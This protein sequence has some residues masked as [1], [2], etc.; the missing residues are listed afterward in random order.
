MVGGGTR[1]ARDLPRRTGRTGSSGSARHL[2]LHGQGGRVAAGEDQPQQVVGEGLGPRDRR[3]PDAALAQVRD[4]GSV[5]PRSSDRAAGGR[6]PCA[7]RRRPASSRLPGI[8]G[9][10]HCL[11]RPPRVPPA[12]CL[13]RGRSRGGAVGSG[14]R[15]RAR[16]PCG[17]A[18]RSMGRR[19]AVNRRAAHGAVY[20]MGGVG[21]IGRTSIEPVR[22]AGMPAASLIASSRSL[23]STR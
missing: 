9:K 11:D 23:A 10:G 12:A 21:R 15:G 1:K 20:S 16:S 4:L 14:W 22:E 6:W 7:A 18:S 5:W 2:R 17:T 3:A 13:R 8:P 19:P